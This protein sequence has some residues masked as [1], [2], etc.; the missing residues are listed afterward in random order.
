MSADATPGYRARDESE[1]S[2]ESDESDE[3]SRGR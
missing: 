3:S 1:A 2:D